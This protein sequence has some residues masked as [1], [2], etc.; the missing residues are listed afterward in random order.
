MKVLAVSNKIKVVNTDYSE[1]KVIEFGDDLY[2][3]GIG[4]PNNAGFT[5]RFRLDMR[6]WKG[7]QQESGKTYRNNIGVFQNNNVIVD[8][9]IDLETGYFDENAHLA[10]VLATKHKYFYINGKRYFRNSDYE[11]NWD[12]SPGDILMLAPAK[13]TFVE[14]GKGFTNQA[15]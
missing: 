7:R 2:V 9:I 13:A 8:K 11:I 3:F 6:T 14:Q 12:D 10:L 4:Y 5:Q 1:T 15:C